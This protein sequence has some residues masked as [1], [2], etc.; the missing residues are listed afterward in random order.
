LKEVEIFYSD[1]DE[2]L[3][4]NYQKDI[5]LKINNSA[6]EQ[7]LG[8]L[9]MTPLGSV[10][11][12]PE[13]GSE[14]HEILFENMNLIQADRLRTRIEKSIKENEPRV[15]LQRVDVNINTL[16]ENTY[17]VYITYKTLYDDVESYTL[18][19]PINALN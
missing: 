5:G 19:I 2:H 11:F 7:A 12:R 8:L 3:T 18:H 1:F 4:P 13:F 10:P 6:I 15:E 14:I 16:H 17:D 9:I